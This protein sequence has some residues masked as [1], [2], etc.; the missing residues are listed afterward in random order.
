MN[1]SR[2]A[3]AAIALS[4]TALA[5]CGDDKKS[6]PATTPVKTTTVVTGDTDGD[7]EGA[8]TVATD[9]ATDPECGAVSAKFG[10]L[11]R[12]NQ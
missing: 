12:M 6:T 4:A 3:V 11:P 8:G 7:T 10:P 2:L 9:A 1:R 5:A